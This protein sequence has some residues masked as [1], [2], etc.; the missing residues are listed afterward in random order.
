MRARH[1]AIG[2]V[3][4]LGLLLGVEIV[5]PATR[6][7]APE[8]ADRLLYACLERGLSFKVGQGNVVVLAPPLT[9]AEADL[10]RALDILEAALDSL[11]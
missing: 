3:R 10:E 11:A 8:A 4:G 5:D 2:D 9:I 1:G 6:R 7:P